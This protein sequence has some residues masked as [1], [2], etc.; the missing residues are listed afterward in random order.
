MPLL[1]NSSKQQ[2][3]VLYALSHSSASEIS[4]ANF[5]VARHLRHLLHHHRNQRPLL[6]VR[7]V[8][9]KVLVS[10]HLRLLARLILILNPICPSVAF[11]FERRLQERPLRSVL[12][13]Q[14]WVVTWFLNTYRSFLGI[15]RYHLSPPSRQISHDISRYISTQHTRNSGKYRDILLL[16]PYDG[17]PEHNAAVKVHLEKPL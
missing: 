2:W 3:C 13:L 5:L 14:R 6:S 7:S 11:P 17:T 4:G 1:T 8:T 16:K 9:P 12:Q 15:Y 10:P